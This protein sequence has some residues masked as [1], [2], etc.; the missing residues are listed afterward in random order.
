[1]ETLIQRDFVMKRK[2]CEDCGEGTL[3][4]GDDMRMDKYICTD[5]SIPRIIDNCVLLSHD[6]LLN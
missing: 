4:F 1:M 2:I 6:S 3:E 5:C